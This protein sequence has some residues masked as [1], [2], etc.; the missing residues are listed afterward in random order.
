MLAGQGQMEIELGLDVGP[1]FQDGVVVEELA[2]RVFGR[3]IIASVPQKKKARGLA[4][5]GEKRAVFSPPESPP[6]AIDP[7]G[8]A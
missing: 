5:G 7:P 2:L 3:P 4:S 6:A 8:G 1:L